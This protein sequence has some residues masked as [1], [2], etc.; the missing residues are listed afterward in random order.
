MSPAEKRRKNMYSV[1]MSC[2]YAQVDHYHLDVGVSTL[3]FNLNSFSLDCLL[4][5][6][7]RSIFI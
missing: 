3:C 1:K 7:H 2:L 4:T 5:V 6:Y